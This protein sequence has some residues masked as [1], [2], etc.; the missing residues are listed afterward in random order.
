MSGPDV[1]PVCGLM[2]WARCEQCVGEIAR[3]DGGHDDQDAPL[4]GVALVDD[5]GDTEGGDCA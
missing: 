3:A 1:C 5:C 4:P 2:L